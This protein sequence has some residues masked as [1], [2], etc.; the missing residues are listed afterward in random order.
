MVHVV[1]LWTF[2][3]V[4]LAGYHTLVCFYPPIWINTTLAVRGF[5]WNLSL[6]AF[7]NVLRFKLTIFI[8]S[9]F[10]LVRGR[11]TAKYKIIRK[12]PITNAPCTTKTSCNYIILTLPRKYLC[13]TR[14]NTKRFSYFIR[15]ILKYQ[16]SS[17]TSLY[18]QELVLR[19]LNGPIPYLIRPFHKIVTQPH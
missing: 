11:C 2:F 6:A 7:P 4:T 18:K 13:R 5:R 8:P 19:A 1:L 10:Y 3:L 17:Y 16:F 14:N 12:F 15:N 9:S